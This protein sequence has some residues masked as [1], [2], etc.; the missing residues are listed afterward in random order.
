MLSISDVILLTS[1]VGF[2]DS[3]KIK[4]CWCNLAF[5]CF[6]VWFWKSSWQDVKKLKIPVQ[7]DLGKILLRVFSS[8]IANAVCVGGACSWCAMLWHREH[9]FIISAAV[10]S[11][12]KPTK[13]WQIREW[14]P[15]PDWVCSGCCSH[16]W[17]QL[18]A[19]LTPWPGTTE[20]HFCV[21]REDS[22]F[23]IPLISCGVVPLFP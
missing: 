10:Q 4:L 6:C 23:L 13:E 11:S 1:Q 12:L 9:A 18:R 17:L 21:I 5:G 15:S 16:A 7:N 3:S 14:V 22:P 8:I 20:W 2:K 19:S